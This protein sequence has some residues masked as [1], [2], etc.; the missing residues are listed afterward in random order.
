MPLSKLRRS[1]E[2][3][4][5]VLIETLRKGELDLSKQHQLYGAI[6]EI[7]NVLKAVEYYQEEHLKGSDFELKRE[8]P[9][10]LRART[11]IFA[12]QVTLGAKGAA[13][14]LRLG[15]VR[16]G[17]GTK[18]AVRGLG[19]SVRLIKEVAREVKARSRKEKE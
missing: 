11:A 12:A 1:F 4:R 18:R 13:R 14:T 5:L 10:P 2:E 17:K 8:G 9:R 15:I 7:E 3:R 16:V 6:K 19:K